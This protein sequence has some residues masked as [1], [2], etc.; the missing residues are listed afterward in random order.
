MVITRRIIRL[1][2]VFFFP[3]FVFKYYLVYLAD[4]RYEKAY[5]VPLQNH[6]GEKFD[7][8]NF[9]DSNGKNVKLDFT[10]SEITII[11]FWFSDCPPC[12]QEMKQFKNLISG[13]DKEIRIISIS[14]NSYSEWT[15]V[16]KSSSNRFSFLSVPLSNWEHLLMRSVEDPKLNNEIP[17][18]NLKT[19]SNR[20]QS[21]NFPMNFVVDKTGTIIASPFSVVDFIKSKVYEQSKTIHFF[22]DKRTWSRLYSILFS[23]LV[24][25]SGYYWLLILIIGGLQS[26]RRSH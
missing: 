18:D 20:F 15:R 2:F 8:D 3:F 17:G 21:Q 13:K 7:I 26:F 23:S 19:L 12:L 16:L 4:K 22:T 24:Q 10:H 11:D 14:I 6:L 5:T 9:I 25:Y 1:W